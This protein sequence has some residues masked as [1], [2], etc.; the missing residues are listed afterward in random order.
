MPGRIVTTQRLLMRPH[1][2]GDYEA[3]CALWADPEVT[4]HITGAPQ[5]AASSWQRLLRYAGHWA[6]LDFGFWAVV[7]Q[8]SGRYI[9]DVGLMQARRALGERF[10]SAPEIGW[11]LAPSAQGKGYA[12][13]AVTAAIDW[14]HTRF[15][16]TRLVCMITPDNAPS[17][18]VAVKFGFEVFARTEYA[19]A[20]VELYERLP[21]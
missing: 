13:E 19:G 6:L 15:G 18:R 11:S 1:E 20:A 7:E 4:R 16:L 9:G 2:R 10:D 8:A 17:Q 14:A 21:P 3:L 12:R 5:D